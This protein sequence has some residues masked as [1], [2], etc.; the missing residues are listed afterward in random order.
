MMKVEMMIG[1]GNQHQ[2]WQDV[3]EFINSKKQ[4]YQSGSRIKG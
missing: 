2:D 3:V 1:F 4:L